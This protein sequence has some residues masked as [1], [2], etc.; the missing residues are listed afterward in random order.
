MI[1][2]G[3]AGGPAAQV[4]FQGGEADV[5]VSD[6]IWVARQRAAGQDY[7]FMPYSKAVGGLMV[8]ADDP[9][10]TLADFRGAKIGVAGGP[11]DKSWIILRAYAEKAFGMDLAA[12]TEQVFGAPP[13][14]FKSALDGEIDGA[15]N[16]WHF[17]ARMKAAGMVELVSVAEAG[18]ALGL[19]P[20]T[21]LLG[22]VFKGALVRSDPDLVHAFGRASRE[23]KDLLRVD[24]AAWERLRP[25]MPSKTD[26]EFAALKEGYRAGIPGTGSVDLASARAFFALMA[27]LGG[28]DLVGESA[29]LPE[30]V[31][32]DAGD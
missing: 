29:E 17:M 23:A 3:M 6:W 14:I 10:K 24:D 31:F 28:S 26:A 30:G 21:P 16:Y 7:V 8:R 32:L 4:A 19:D 1:V 2:Q 12:E 15:V 11:L 18:A 20:E 25:M 13:L 27:Q 5:I 9:R 22:Y